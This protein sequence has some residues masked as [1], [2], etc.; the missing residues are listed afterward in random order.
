MSMVDD[1][2]RDLSSVR[3]WRG[4]ESVILA[5]LIE[6]HPNGSSDA[7]MLADITAEDHT[8][9]LS[10]MVRGAIEGL[11]AVDLVV[12]SEGLLYPTAAALRSGELELGL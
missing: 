1:P 4:I 5:H 6:R 9:G 11:I 2:N 10:E 7:E 12:R 3:G 8:P